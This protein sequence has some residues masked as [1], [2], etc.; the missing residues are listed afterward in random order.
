MAETEVYW[1]S[2]SP[3]SW[4][5][6]LALEVKRIEY[7]SHRLD[8]AKKEQKSEAFLA[9]NPRGQVPVVK[10]GDV[11]V[12]ETLAVLAY[13][14]RAYPEP[15][16]FGGDA[17]RTAHIW[18]LACECDSFLRNPVGTISRPLFRGK[19]EAFRDEITAAVPAVRDELDALE[20]N[21]EHTP[22][23]A[24]E[25]ISAADLVYYPVIMQLARAAGRD[26]ARSLNL[27]LMPL[28]DTFPAL[29]AWM[30]RIENIPG[31]DLTYPPHWR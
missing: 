2:G 3:P 28:A 1:I 11:V 14:D 20:G 21:L 17:E 27:G 25:T 15:S 19:A 4:S 7:D 10:H 23:L 12:R 29:A 6:L 30:T 9:V 31:Y 22:F 13:L 8:N 5:A 26:D 18:Q 24:G 16:L